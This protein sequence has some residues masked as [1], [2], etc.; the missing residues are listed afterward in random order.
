MAG[1]IIVVALPDAGQRLFSLSGQHGPSFIDALGIA[2]LLAGW[3][4]S[5]LRSCGVESGSSAEPAS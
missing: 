4:S 5:S 3:S 2:F 1:G